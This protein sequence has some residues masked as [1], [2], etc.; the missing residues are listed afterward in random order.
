MGAPF[1]DEGANDHHFR[2]GVVGAA[3]MAGESLGAG[4]RREEDDRVAAE[5]DIVLER[6]LLLVRQGAYRGIELEGL[7]GLQID[8]EG[9]VGHSLSLP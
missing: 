7:E 2:H 9:F 1:G 6:R 3:G 5:L 8:G 4:E